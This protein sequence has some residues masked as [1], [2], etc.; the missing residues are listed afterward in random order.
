MNAKEHRTV[1][2]YPIPIITPQCL[3]LSTQAL[4]SF[5]S[6][7]IPAA[8]RIIKKTISHSV[9][10]SEANPII[11]RTATRDTHKKVP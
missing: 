9:Q 6:C 4:G 8:N 10:N 5:R 7:I 2:T 3:G 11:C 1:N